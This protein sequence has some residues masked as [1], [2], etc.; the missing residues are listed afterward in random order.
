MKDFVINRRNSWHY[1]FNKYFFNEYTDYMYAW[2]SRHMDF[3]SYWRATVLRGVF[4]SVLTTLAGLFCS[5]VGIAIYN[6]PV[7]FL[8]TIFG[9]LIVIALAFAIA[10]LCIHFDSW[11]KK[12]KKQDSLIM[13]K[14]KAHKSKYCPMV[15]YEKDEE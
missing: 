11:P 12:N 15:T 4:A 6:N 2:E 14:R 9:I 10:E 13:Q 8:C 5:V 1:K 3:C 7:A